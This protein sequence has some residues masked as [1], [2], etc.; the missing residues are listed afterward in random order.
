[1]I[2]SLEKSYLDVKAIPGNMFKSKFIVNA[3]E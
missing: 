3:L 1:M 2:S